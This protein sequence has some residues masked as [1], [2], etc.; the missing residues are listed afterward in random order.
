[1]NAQISYSLD[2]YQESMIS[3]AGTFMSGILCVLAKDLLLCQMNGM[4]MLINLLPIFPLDGGRLTKQI[5]IHLGGKSKGIQICHMISL[6]CLEIFFFMTIFL[7]GYL[8]KIQPLFFAFY[9]GELSKKAIQK[10]RILGIISYL[11][12]S[13]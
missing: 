3:L 11:Q 6:V 1:M 13:E 4:I 10:E 2:G 7:V 5:C 8:R 9:L 12:T